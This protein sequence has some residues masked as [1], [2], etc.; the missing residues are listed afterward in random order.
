MTVVEKLK[1][2]RKKKYRKADHWYNL[3]CIRKLSHGR[4]RK[5]NQH[6]GSDRK[7]LPKDGRNLVHTNPFAFLV[8]AVFNRGMRWEKA[9]EIPCCIDQKGLLDASKL[10]AM[11]EPEL[12]RFLKRLRVKP[13]YWKKGAKTLKEAATLVVNEFA[14]DAAAIWR[15]TSLEKVEKRL[16]RINGVGPGIASMFTRILH[17]DCGMFRGQEQQ[18]DVKPD[19]HLMRVFKRTG[20]THS[21]LEKE[22]RNAARTLNPAFPGELDWPAFYIGGKWCHEKKEPNCGECPLEAACPSA[23]EFLLHPSTP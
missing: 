7:R 5:K 8:G 17:D 15:N 14:G 12:K 6:S 3:C 4:Y 23:E 22:A 19:M 10:A 21:K 13:R 16:K 9:W 2:Y 20:L 18:I 11:S 1:E